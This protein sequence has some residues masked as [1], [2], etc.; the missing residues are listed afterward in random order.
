[1]DKIKEL[2]GDSGT[3]AKDIPGIEKPGLQTQGSRTKSHSSEEAPSLQDVMA[4]LSIPVV[5]LLVA[6]ELFGDKL[7]QG[8]ENL[9][10]SEV[11]DESQPIQ[12]EFGAKLTH[13][14]HANG[15]EAP[16]NFIFQV[17]GRKAGHTPKIVP[18]K[19]AMAVGIKD[20]QVIQYGG[21][22]H[23]LE[24]G[25]LTPLFGI[26][27]KN[28]PRIPFNR[29]QIKLGQG[30]ATIKPRSYMSM[31]AWAYW[32]EYPELKTSD[33]A[34]IQKAVEVIKEKMS[35]PENAFEETTDEE[36]AT[37]APSVLQ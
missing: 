32:D 20:Y 23:I 33:D 31:I 26:S 9:F 2:T 18:G 24:A 22:D 19:Y 16:E 8:G 34:E 37:D 21:Q 28:V 12:G 11:L 15:I 3:Y 6:Q 35:M 5:G 14:L 10:L 25:S 17:F 29:T 7:D 4:E 1:M 13:L 36:I 27:E 30:K